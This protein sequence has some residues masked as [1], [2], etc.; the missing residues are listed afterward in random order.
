MKSSKTLF[1][2]I[3]FISLIFVVTS[4]RSESNSSDNNTAANSITANNTT[5]QDYNKL[6]EL[7]LYSDKQ[8]YKTDEKIIIWATL[9][10]IGSSEKI[11]I[12][13]SNPYISFT[14][15]DGEKFNTGGISDDILTS[16]ILVKDKLYRF[17]YIKSGGFSADEPNADYW[18]KFYQEKDL[19]LPE[20][21]YTVK[22]G[23]AFSL[24]ENPQ[25]S[26]SNLIKELKIKIKN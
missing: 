22:V 25:M 13:H 10:Y 12:W 23:G 24:N 19:H 21:E 20:G 9:K 18:K 8:T 1:L 6:F 5:I 2:F 7:N 14:I 15:T 17:D 26:K 4:C 11:K 16:T 3:I